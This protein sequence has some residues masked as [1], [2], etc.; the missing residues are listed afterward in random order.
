MLPANCPAEHLLP[1][2]A[3]MKTEYPQRMPYPKGNENDVGVYGKL[4]NGQRISGHL[5]DTVRN[6]IHT[7]A[8]ALLRTGDLDR[9]LRELII[10]RVGYSLGSYYE[11][12]QHG[13]LARSFGVPAEKVLAM[14]CKAPEGLDEAESAV[15]SFVDELLAG[16]EVPDKVLADVQAKFTPGQVLEIVWV[17]GNWWTLARMLTVAGIPSDQR[18]IGEKGVASKPQPETK[19]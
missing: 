19:E 13:S 10:V 17:T 6:G 11:V 8:G 15:I 18:K 1:G 2:A 3:A 14:A 7:L 9:Q 12:D 4:T 5:N 16:G